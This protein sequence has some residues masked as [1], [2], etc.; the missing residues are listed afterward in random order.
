MSLIRECQPNAL[1][2]WEKFYFEKSYTRQ[3]D[4]TKINRDT[5]DE[6]GERLYAKI[7]E[8]V[9]PE[10]TAAFEDLTLQDCKD[11]IYE[12]TIV[13]TYDGFRLEKSVIN[14]GLSKIFPEIE[15]EE[16]DPV[17][18]HAGDIDYLCKVGDKAFGVQIKPVTANANFDNYKITERMSVSFQG[19]EEKYGGKV[20][21][22]FSMRAGDRK[23]IINE[24]IIKEIRTEIERLKDTS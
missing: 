3:K 20:F 17:L 8:V 23:V 1:E 12:V 22:I 11:Y 2:E 4:K 5:L 14:D 21:V 16:S 15:F 13:R 7:T 18:D 24:E 9:I 6:L 10:W 19:F